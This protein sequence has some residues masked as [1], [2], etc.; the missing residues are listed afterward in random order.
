MSLLSLELLWQY[1]RLSCCRCIDDVD[2]NC[3]EMFFLLAIIIIEENQFEKAR[4]K[5]RKALI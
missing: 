3:G 2:C 1:Y 5:M 4:A